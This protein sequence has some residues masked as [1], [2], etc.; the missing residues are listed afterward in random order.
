LRIFRWIAFEVG[1][2]QI[3]EQHIEPGS[4]QILPL[5][6]QVPEQ[7]S[8]VLKQVI[9]AAVKLVYLA[10]GTVFTEQVAYR[11]VFKPVPVQAHSLPGSIKR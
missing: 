11:T 1:A 3:V 6:L 7:A 4:K 8:L 10:D 2:G 9:M 5:L